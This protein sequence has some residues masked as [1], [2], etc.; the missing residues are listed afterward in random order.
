MRDASI[1]TESKYLSTPASLL[2]RCPLHMYKIVFF[3]CL[4]ERQNRNFLVR[5]IDHN[6]CHQLQLSQPTASR[7]ITLVT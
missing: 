7:V 1:L 3:Y 2:H 6:F 5:M 4:A